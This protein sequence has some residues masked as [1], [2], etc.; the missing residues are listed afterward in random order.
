METCNRFHSRI[1]AFKT[2]FS[3][4]PRRIPCGLLPLN[5]CPLSQFS[6]CSPLH[7]PQQI[8]AAGCS[9]C[10]PAGSLPATGVAYVQL[11]PKRIT[12][13]PSGS[14]SEPLH[15]LIYPLHIH[16]LIVAKNCGEPARAGSPQ[17]LTFPNQVPCCL[18]IFK[19]FFYL[20]IIQMHSAT[21][22]AVIPVRM[23]L[24][25]AGNTC[26]AGQSAA[27]VCRAQ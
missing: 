26:R 24:C 8:S 12:G 20:S 4:L 15:F 23:H 7:I 14:F 27:R 3:T 21:A 10:K 2:L 17:S 19:A 5:R 25:T 18:L 9:G 1:A 6:C 11:P 13:R 22:Q 16:L